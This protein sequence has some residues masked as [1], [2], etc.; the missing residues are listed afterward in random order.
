MDEHDNEES[1]RSMPWWPYAAGCLGVLALA[2]LASVALP[3]GGVMWWQDSTQRADEAAH[4]EQ[5]Q[6]ADAV[7]A[8]AIDALGE[9]A[10]APAQRDYSIDKTV[11]VI[12]G[13]DLALKD[14]PDLES[15][16][17]ELARQ[18]YR[19]VA[20]EV[21]EGRREIL[22]ILRPLYAKQTELEEQQ[23]MWEMTSELLLATLSIVSVSG[24][25]NLVNP[26]GTF[27]VDRDRAKVLWDDLKERQAHHEQL[28][29]DIAE[30]DEK[31]FGVLVD[32]A[33]VYWGYIEEWDRLSLL[34]DRAYL[35]VHEQDWAAAEAAAGKAI[36]QA[37]EEREAHLLKA[38]AILEQGDPERLSEAEGLLL[39]QIE[40]HPDQTAPAFLLLG[41]MSAKVGDD[42]QARLHL[43]QAAAYYPKQSERL[44]DMLDPYKMRAFL[45][46]SREGQQI[47]EQYQ[48]T[49]LGS[50][51]FSPDLQLAR[52]HFEDDDF[53]AGRAKVLDH[54]ARRRSQEQ[55][56]FVISD[57]SFCQEL[58][59]SDFRKIFP[60]DAWLDLE[61]SSSMMGLGS[62][63][64]LAVRNRGDRTLHNA[65]LVLALHLTDMFPGQ[66]TAVPA[67]E[68]V[69]AVVAHEVTSFG[70]LDPELDVAGKQKSVS[71]TVKHRA[72]LISDEAVVWVDT[73]EFKIAEHEEF[74]KERQAVKAGVRPEAKPTVTSQALRSTYDSLVS[75]LSKGV[76]LQ[77]E[78]KFGKD[79][80]LIEL[81]REL[82][83]LRPV[84]RLK[85]GEETLLAEDNLIEGDRIVL[86]FTG[87]DNFDP[88]DPGSAEDLELVLGSP[89]GDMVLRWKTTGELTWDYVG[90]SPE[91]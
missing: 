9:A 39:D 25:M 2:G 54:F 81:P 46:K 15:Y 60:E 8:P 5:E 48:A 45:Q 87:V 7:F 27:A 14:Q 91:E 24:E 6:K 86:R 75:G 82:S 73:D 11:R 47:L 28:Q 50:G 35:A 43:Q 68:T 80:V 29:S 78:E 18:D 17:R 58:L 53:E 67:P 40:Q 33:D 90:V 77:I 70:S 74:R 19:D 49:M 10:A 36:E 23:A 88:D 22:Q 57:I 4:A 12:H 42:K 84:F 52:L 55:W 79:S 3:V 16:M 56:D 13:L 34:R 66:Y 1:K 71:D 72:I 32:Y 83:I 31:L 62:G 20:P 63:I 38:L 21:L 89:F 85:Y 61:V 37:P 64:N 76:D 65:T 69:P 41:V 44:L 51:Y 26:A 30:L 59:G